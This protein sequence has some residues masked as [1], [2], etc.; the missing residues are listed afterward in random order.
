MSTNTQS[1]QAL[2]RSQ[3]QQTDKEREKRERDKRMRSPTGL[4]KYALRHWN[5]SGRVT[6]A[7]RAASR[8]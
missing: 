8:W 4:S 2:T 7:H 1:T 3:R 6:G 5:D